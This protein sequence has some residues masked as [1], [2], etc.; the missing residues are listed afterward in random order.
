MTLAASFRCVLKI[1]LDGFQFL[2]SFWWPVGPRKNCSQTVWFKMHTTGTS[3]TQPRRANRCFKGPQ[4]SRGASKHR[5]KRTSRRPFF[6]A[7][8]RSYI[9]F[10]KD[11]PSLEPAP[12]N[13]VGPTDVSKGH[14]SHGKHDG[15]CGE[16]VYHKTGYRSSRIVKTGT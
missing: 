11:L 1:V 3:S 9:N 8:A 14:G 5:R 2:D 15:S 4:L 10:G 12:Q 6:H 13:H 7:H 16:H